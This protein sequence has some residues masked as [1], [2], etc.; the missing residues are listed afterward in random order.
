MGAGVNVSTGMGTRTTVVGAATTGVGV[1]VG[2]VSGTP[3]PSS[4]QAATARIMIAANAHESGIKYARPLS[5]GMSVSSSARLDIF[6]WVGC[7][8]CQYITRIVALDFGWRRVSDGG[9]GSPR[10]IHG[11]AL[12]IGGTAGGSRRSDRADLVLWDRSEMFSLF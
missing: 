5:C 2:T 8:A 1:S 11:S 6:S 12:S 7:D 4:P 10:Q 3:A 9:F